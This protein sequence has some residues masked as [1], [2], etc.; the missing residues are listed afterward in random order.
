MRT[1]SQTQRRERSRES[2]DAHSGDPHCGRSKSEPNMSEE[3][4]SL[5]L[6]AKNL[7]EL[8]QLLV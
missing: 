2:F 4:F 7:C 1:A 3:K 8:S 6:Q 5:T